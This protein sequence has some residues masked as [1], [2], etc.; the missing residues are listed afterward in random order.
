KLALQIHHEG[1]VRGMML[2]PD[3]PFNEFMDK[4]T[5]RFGIP[6]RSS[7]WTIRTSCSNLDARSMR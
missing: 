7:S 2:S 1:D 3:T 5:S 4:V 6:S